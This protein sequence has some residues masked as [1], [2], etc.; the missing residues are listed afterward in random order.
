MEFQTICVAGGTGQIKSYC[1]VELLEAEWEWSNCDNFVNSFNG[2]KGTGP[3][4]KRVV[5]ITGKKVTFYQSDLS[6]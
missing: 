4:L 6:D 1:V 3:S 5:K 2:V